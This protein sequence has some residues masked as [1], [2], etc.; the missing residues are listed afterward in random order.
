[1]FTYS[2]R[3]FWRALQ[4]KDG[5][6]ADRREADRTWVEARALSALSRM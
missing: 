6:I 5:K 3:N 1:L 2:S 4:K